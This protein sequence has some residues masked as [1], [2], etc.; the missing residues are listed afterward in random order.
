MA[1]HEKALA[2]MKDYAA[3][4]DVPELKTFAGDTVKVVEAH[5]A[6]IKAM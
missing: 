1:A 3:N 4:G 2:A 6:K 5:L